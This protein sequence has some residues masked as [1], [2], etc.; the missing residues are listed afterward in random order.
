[1]PR[2]ERRRLR[3]CMGVLSA[4][5][6]RAVTLTL[7]GTALHNARTKLGEMVSISKC[8]I[9]SRHHA[10][11]VSSFQSIDVSTESIDV[12]TDGWKVPFSRYWG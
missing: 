9:I 8:K 1:M 7:I 4:A 5:S 11:P 12:S 2:S 3:A 6:R 10:V